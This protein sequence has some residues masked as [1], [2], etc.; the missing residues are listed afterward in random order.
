MLFNFNFNF[1]PGV[2]LCCS[3]LYNVT[4]SIAFSV[5]LTDSKTDNLYLYLMY[6]SLAIQYF[7]FAWIFIL[8][9]INVGST[10]PRVVERISV[11]RNVCQWI[12]SPIV[13]LGYSLVE[14]YALH[15]VMIK[16]RE[17]CKHGASK[18]DELKS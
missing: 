12:L 16:G 4:F 5:L 14:F 3:S 13:V 6:S 7:I 9:R 15:E 10:V 2:I 1:F 17:V 18:K 8:D 11:V